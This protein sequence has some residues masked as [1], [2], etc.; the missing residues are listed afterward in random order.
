[1]AKA[2]RLTTKDLLAA[3][4]VTPMTIA[5]WRKGTPT[6]TPLPSEKQ[7]RSVNYRRD[8]IERWADK[9]GV[10]LLDPLALLGSAGR[11]KPGPKVQTREETA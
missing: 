6:R 2:T 1:M 8:R 5:N 3:F 11:G 9:N 7:G 4:G 10:P